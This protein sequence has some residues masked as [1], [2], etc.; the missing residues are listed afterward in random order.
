MNIYLEIIVL[1]TD[2]SFA[3][4]EGSKIQ[5]RF[6]ILL[7]DDN[8]SWKILLFGS[9][10]CPHIARLFMAPGIQALI[11]GLDNSFVVQEVR[12][13]MEVI[14]G[15]K[16]KIEDKVGS[17]TGFNVIEKGDTTTEI[18]LQLDI[19]TLRQSYDLGQLD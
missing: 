19:I 3:N 15:K 6:I 1:M 8:G 7:A 13:M 16:M 10:R 14:L 11:L 5:L 4:A 17:I 18:R 9:K 2:A 12:E